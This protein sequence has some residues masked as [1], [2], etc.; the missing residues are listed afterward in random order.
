MGIREQEPPHD[1]LVERFSRRTIKIGSLVGGVE[2]EVTYDTKVEKPVR[3]RV[4]RH[5]GGSTRFPEQVK[6]EYRVFREAKREHPQE[7]DL[8]SLARKQTIFTLT[9]KDDV[10]YKEFV[11]A[12]TMYLVSWDNGSSVHIMDEQ[13]LNQLFDAGE[14]PPDEERTTPTDVLANA[15]DSIEDSEYD[16]DVPEQPA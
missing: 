2:K 15:L 16:T 1:L 14:V 6:V 8:S 11:K 9:N 5:N 7:G 12:E 4:E 3:E 10:S 13:E